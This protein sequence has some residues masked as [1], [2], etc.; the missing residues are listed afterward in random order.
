MAD[1]NSLNINSSTPLTPS[2]GGTGVSNSTHTLTIGANSAINQDVQTSSSPAFNDLILTGASINFTGGF[3]MLGFTNVASSVNYVDIGNNITGLAPT[4]ASTGSDPNIPLL[5]NTTGSGNYEFVTAATTQQFLISTGS[6]DNFLT[7]PI[8]GSNTY[9]FQTA[10][11]TLAFSGAN[12]DITSMT[13]LNGV[14]QAPTFINDSNGNH[15][16]GFGSVSTAVNYIEMLNASTGNEPIIFAA[17]SD[18]NVIFGIGSKGGQFS[19]YDI[20][21]TNPATIK[22]ND[23]NNGHFIAILGQSTL[24]N[25]YNQTLQASSGT[26]CID[27]S[28]SGSI[29]TSPPN[30]SSPS[31]ALGTNYQNSAGYDVILTVYVSI[32]AATAGSLSLGVGSAT[33]PTQQ[34]IIASL[35]TAAIVVVPVP[36]YIPS[37]YY[38]LLSTGGTITASIS[39]QIAMPV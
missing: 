10:S 6:A 38:A 12:S 37:G 30:S 28:S 36:I 17:G 3:P 15:I 14:I 22:F 16:L 35:T 21:S 9:T 13:G 7:F 24:S 18:S 5:F 2:R 33:G 34:T 4:I 11:G 26:L 32:T 25:N 1:N 39:G 27:S 19:F 23:S 8:T 29:T 31:L 20:S